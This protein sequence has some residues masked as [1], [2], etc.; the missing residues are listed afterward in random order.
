[1]RRTARRLLAGL[2]IIVVGLAAGGPGW[3]G[4]E[5]ID[6]TMRLRPAPNTAGGGPG[7]QD[8]VGEPSSFEMRGFPSIL[9]DPSLPAQPD[10]ILWRRLQERFPDRT[11]MDLLTQSPAELRTYLAEAAARDPEQAQA[12]VELGIAYGVQERH[13]DAEHTSPL[14]AP[15]A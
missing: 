11:P 4:D 2:S 13:D 7:W 10:G 6:R 15:L 12:L 3:A 14:P 8:P 1:V 5:V 9:R